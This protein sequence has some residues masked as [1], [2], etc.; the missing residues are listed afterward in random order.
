MRRFVPDVT[1][2]Q[3]AGSNHCAVASSSCSVA[4]VR[5]LGIGSGASGVPA[6]DTVAALRGS[7]AG[8]ETRGR[9]PHD[10]IQQA[11][12]RHTIVTGDAT[13]HPAWFN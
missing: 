13:G 7:F 2:S 11:L 12:S 1:G 10:A 6:L 5:A 4:I 9:S 8:S 3:V